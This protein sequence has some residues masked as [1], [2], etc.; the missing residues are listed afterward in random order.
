MKTIEKRQKRAALIA[1]ARGIIDRAETDKR[2]LTQEE[3][4]QWDRIMTD[5]DNLKGDIDREER[6]ILADNELEHRGN[7]PVNPI[8][9]ADGKP[10]GRRATDEYQKEFRNFIMNGQIEGRAIQADV[11]ASGGYLFAPEQFVAK[12][13]KSLDDAVV[14]RNLSTSMQV[15]SSDNLGF[16]TLA[17]DLNDSD[18]TTE[19]QPVAN[20]AALTLGKR[21]MTPHYLTKLVKISQK[22]LRVSA[23]PADTLVADRM[24]YKFAITQ[25]KAFITGSGIGQPLGV[26]T[27]SASGISTSRDIATGNTAT[28]MTADGLLEA[29]YNLK[30]QYRRNCQWLFHRDGVKQVAKLKDSEGQYLWK[31]S[32]ATGEPDMLLGYAVNESEYV[33]NTFTTGQ[34]VG[35]LGDFKQYWIV[36]NLQMQV[37]RLIELYAATNEIGFIG[38]METDGAPVDQLAFSRIKLA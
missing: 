19:I 33:P 1:E 17:T 38:R 22:L 9:G 5:S 27:A 7:P 32:I 12:L 21:N 24:A 34:Y 35:L 3:R 11:D 4:N 6:Q 18:W 30:A 16:P 29:K 25:E 36:D 37:Q 10:I 15:T 2:E 8:V 20:D 26:F 31:A 23:L 13:I 28:A 14:M